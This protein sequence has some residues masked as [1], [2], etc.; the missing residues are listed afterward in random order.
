MRSTQ[1]LF[2]WSFWCA[3]CSLGCGIGY[4]YLHRIP[5]PSGDHQ[6]AKAASPEVSLAAS[7][8]KDGFSEV[9]NWLAHFPGQF[10]RAF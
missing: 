4:G 6:P 3:A 7:P 8:L 1:L 10:V 2:N 9:W 5:V